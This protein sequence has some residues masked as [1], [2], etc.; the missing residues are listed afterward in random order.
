[1]KTVWLMAAI[2]L[3]VSPALAGETQRVDLF[4]PYGERLGYAEVDP[5]TGRA[6]LFDT[7][8]RRKGYGTVDSRGVVSTF[9]TK[10]QRIAPK[11][12]GLGKGK[13]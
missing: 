8:A 11:A 2:L 6:D 9:N 4:S 12:F 3:G 13:R 1:M 7:K 5:K 10:G